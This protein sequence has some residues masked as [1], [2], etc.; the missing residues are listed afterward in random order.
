MLG[1]LSGR[2]A[3]PIVALAIIALAWHSLVD[4]VYAQQSSAPRRVGVLLVAWTPA[5]KMVQ[6]FRSGLQDAGYVEGRDVVLEWRTANGDYQRVS[7]LAAELVRLGVDVIVTDSTP[8][9]R[10]VKQATSTIPIVMATVGDPVGSG[11]VASLAHPGGNVTG[12]SLIMTDLAAKRLELLKEL[13]PG[14]R[15]VGVVWDPNVIWH[16]GAL[17]ELSSAARSLSLDVKAFRV[18]RRDEFSAAFSAMR[19]SHVQA[20]YV[21]ESAF[22][23]ANKATLLKVAFEARLPVIYGEKAVAEEGA[24]MSYAANFE[25]MWRR[26]AGYVDKVL[27]GV[28]PADLPIEQPSAL[29]LVINMKTAKVLGISVPESLLQRAD[30]LIK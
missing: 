18:G 9:T 23:V 27:K 6:A 17:D 5:D 16:K 2:A 11:I 8:A 29:V 22:Y 30:E 13:L 21:L 10:A 1:Q 25:D 4:A 24:L 15:R 7:S 19:H 14:L 20:V 26:S 3:S 12:L 28:R